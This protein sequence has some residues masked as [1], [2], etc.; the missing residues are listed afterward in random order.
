MDPYPKWWCPY[1]KGE[2]GHTRRM[3]CGHGKRD[4]GVA[5]T[6]QGTIKIVSKPPE[7]MGEAWN[8]LF[9]TV[10]RSN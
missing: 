3:P 6:N 10:L 1:E 9:V 4:Q 2:S 5:P 8:R 7:A